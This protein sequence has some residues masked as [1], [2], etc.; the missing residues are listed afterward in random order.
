MVFS[1]LNI[2]D[3]RAGGRAASACDGLLRGCLHRGFLDL[4]VR[5]LLDL[6]QGAAPGRRDALRDEQDA[7]TSLADFLDQKIFAGQEAEVLAPV[8][9]DVRGFAAYLERFRAVVELERAA[10][11][12]IP[13]DFTA[14]S[15]TAATTH[16]KDHR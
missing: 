13:A 10:T 3:S 1:V 4:R 6:L 7:D 2:P 16:R 5:L 14:D 12:L 11:D 15:T 9:R 8:D